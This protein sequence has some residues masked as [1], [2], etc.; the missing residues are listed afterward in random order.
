MPTKNE[1]LFLQD[2]EHFGVVNGRHDVLYTLT[3]RKEQLIS[4]STVLFECL[5]L[6]SPECWV[7]LGGD[8]NYRPLSVGSATVYDLIKKNLS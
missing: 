8:G 7:L 2:N 4:F 1:L 3:R 6:G 5:A